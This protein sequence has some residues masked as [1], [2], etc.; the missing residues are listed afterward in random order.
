MRNMHDRE[1]PP[2]RAGDRAGGGK[3]G[4]SAAFGAGGYS[5]QHKGGKEETRRGNSIIWLCGARGGRVRAAG[6]CGAGVKGSGAEERGAEMKGLKERKGVVRGKRVKSGGECGR[7]ESAENG[8]ARQSE[9]HGTE[10]KQSRKARKSEE[11]VKTAGFWRRNGCRKSRAFF[12]KNAQRIWLRSDYPK[13]ARRKTKAETVKLNLLF[14]AQVKLR[15]KNTQKERGQV[16]NTAKNQNAGKLY[17]TFAVFACVERQKTKKSCV[18]RSEP[19]CRDFW[20]MR[21]L[22][23]A[24]LKYKENIFLTFVTVKW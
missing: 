5:G 2:K 8:T 20:K 17:L 18:G 7:R 9:K 11:N 24:A 4:K 1:N 22:L 21:R 19:G 10:E 16:K 3:Q 13:M 14:G 23:A 6:K 15:L 12:V